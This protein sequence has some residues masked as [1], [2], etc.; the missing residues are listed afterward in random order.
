MQRIYKEA[1]NIIAKVDNQHGKMVFDRNKEGV[2]D[3]RIVFSKEVFYSLK[4]V[5]LNE[6]LWNTGID[7]IKNIPDGEFHTIQLFE[8]DFDG[9]KVITPWD[10]LVKNNKIN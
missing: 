5:D 4:G 2:L 8:Q 6:W 7:L 10:K 9:T 1:G 3:I